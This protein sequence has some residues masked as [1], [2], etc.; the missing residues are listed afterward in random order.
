MQPTSAEREADV[1][2]IKGV[3]TPT[4]DQIDRH[5]GAHT[6]HKPWCRH[7]SR[8]LAMGDPHMD[9]EQQKNNK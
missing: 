2:I 4:Q 6:P 8:G 1:H 5:E 9:K 3:D 7:C